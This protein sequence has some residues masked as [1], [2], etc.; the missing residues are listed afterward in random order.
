MLS[1]KVEFYGAFRELAR[2]IVLEIKPGW[3]VADVLL[4]ISQ[5]NGELYAR[6]V[7]T[8]TAV[9]VVNGRLSDLSTPVSDGDVIKFFSSVLGG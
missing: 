5:I 7:Q 4:A 9:V 6:I 2:E 8:E 1:I 3:R